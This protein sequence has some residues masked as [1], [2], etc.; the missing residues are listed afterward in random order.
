MTCRQ[1]ISENFLPCFARHILFIPNL[2]TSCKMQS[3]ALIN[4]IFY[5]YTTINSH[6]I[7]H[8]LG[9][10]H[11]FYRN[12][13]TMHNIL[14]KIEKLKVSMEVHSRKWLCFLTHYLK[15]LLPARSTHFQDI[16]N[17]HSSFLRN[18]FNRKDCS[19]GR[20]DPLLIKTQISFLSIALFQSICAVEHGHKIKILIHFTM[21][22]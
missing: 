4:I 6:E 18:F 14:F 3:T 8:I 13:S 12:S 1:Y 21:A 9:E 15:M 17:L 22:Q 10:F 19:L 7:K 11:Y 2:G 5:K 20:H 16:T